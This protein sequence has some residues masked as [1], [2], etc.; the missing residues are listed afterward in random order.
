[1]T[2]RPRSA[3]TKVSVVMPVYNN[4]AELPEQLTSLAA[5]T[6]RGDWEIV[7]ADNGSTDGTRAVAES[8]AAST[9]R[10]RVIDASARRG[11][12]AARNLGA[13]VADGDLLCFCDGDDVLVPEW[14]DELVKAAAANDFVGGR[15]DVDALT[16][17]HAR[18]WRSRPAAASREQQ[19]FACA[20]NF[21]IWRDAFEAVGGFD[22]RLGY[23]EDQDL[24]ARL[25]ERGYQMG[26]APD[27][28]VLYRLQTSL[29]G[30]ARQSFRSG[31]GSGQLVY[32]HGGGPTW[33][34]ARE[35]A[36]RIAWIVI[37]LPYLAS[38][39]RRGHLVRA[40]AGTWGFVVGMWTQRR[41]R[42]TGVAA[43]PSAA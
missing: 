41:D 42:Q 15:L 17:E 23:A 30:L 34:T 19:A 7:V 26:W 8:F 1:M 18:G 16:P 43:G 4:E 11:G 21:A 14:L 36:G 40:A 20:G 39:R 5:Q 12:S 6:Y 32:I 31:K 25:K 13:S 3:P 28:V 37:R 38:R 9:G 24:S 27:A 10:L 22:E 35:L 2:A 33:A 29:K